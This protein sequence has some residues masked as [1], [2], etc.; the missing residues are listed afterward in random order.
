M[1]NINI[2]DKAF[3]GYA[4]PTFAELVAQF[5]VDGTLAPERARDMVSGLRSIAKALGRPLKDVP[6]DPRWLQ[7]RLARVAPAALGLRPKTW[8]NIVSNAR[9][10]M[11]HFGIVARRRN[12][13]DDLGPEWRRPWEIVLVSRDPTLRPS[14][15][16]FVHYLNRQGVLPEAVDDHHATAYRDALALNEISRS[17]EVAYRAAVNS[18][19]LAGE[20]IPEWPRTRLL[21]PNR[22]KTITLPT[23][24][25]PRSFY[26]D[27]HRLIDRLLHPNPL[28]ASGRHDPLR[29]ATVKQYRW[30]ILRFASEL[31]QSGIPASEIDR[32]D[33]LIEPTVAERGL[34]QMLSRNGNRSRPGI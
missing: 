33:V 9:A 24:T 7:P 6:A 26:D 3:V 25:F 12:H 1:T 13:L 11:A 22:Q 4:C 10:A 32:L 23:G 16:Q 34:R 8:A 29:V 31:V 2:L 14:L 30:Q 15:C 19:N 20:R 5:S 27:L 21:L 18:W 17:P 28:D